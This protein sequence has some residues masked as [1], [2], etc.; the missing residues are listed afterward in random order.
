M[1]NANIGTII[2]NVLLLPFIDANAEPFAAH[3]KHEHTFNLSEHDH[4]WGHTKVSSHISK[5]TNDRSI[6]IYFVTYRPIRGASAVVLGAGPAHSL[7]FAAYEM[8]KELT[9]KFT[10]VR[11]LNY[12]NFKEYIYQRQWF[13]MYR[14]HCSDFGSGGHP[15]TRRHF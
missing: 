5:I 7:Y 12:G 3:T 8:T 4:P 1:H 6:L 14:I 15:H 2:L 11:N 13:L 10:S 9:A